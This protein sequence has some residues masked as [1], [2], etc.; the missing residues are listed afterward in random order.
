MAMNMIIYPLGVLGFWLCGFGFMLGGV[1]GWPTLGAAL[2]PAHEISLH[3]GGH[4]YG[5]IGA[6]QIRAGLGGQ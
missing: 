2:A 6:R 1:Q 5:I 4:G 3:I